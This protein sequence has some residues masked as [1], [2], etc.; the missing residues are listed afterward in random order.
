M[1]VRLN[2]EGIAI[3]EGISRNKVKYEAIELHKF[4]PSL[5]GKPIL[6]DHENTVDSSVGKVT[7]SESIDGGKRIRY[8]GWVKGEDIIEKIK[9][10][11]ICNVSIGATAMRMVK[12]NQDSEYVIAKG[13]NAL[14][15]SLT[16][17][18]GIADATI[19][20][21]TEESFTEEEIKNAIEDY[22]KESHLQLNFKEEE[23]NMEGNEAEITQSPQETPVE[24]QPQEE[25]KTE[26][27]TSEETKEVEKLKAKLVEAE[28]AVE[29]FKAD[30]RNATIESYKVKCA[31][32]KI[33]PQDVSN[34][35]M[36]TIR[37]LITTVESIQM[38]VV[39]K[40]EMKEKAQPKTKEIVEEKTSESFDGYKLERGNLGWTFYKSY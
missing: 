18:P 20:V 16:P 21:Q 28:K 19:G 11:R 13:L 38:P 5:I 3:T 22:M 37:A 12:E 30:K 2:V 6:C 1:A 25:Q 31:E 14:E 26:V 23:K 7:H 10:G 4:A 27:E 15:L 29:A 9:D 33:V 32:K 8:K 35:S 34:M 40:V 17:V 36:E 24:T 39:E